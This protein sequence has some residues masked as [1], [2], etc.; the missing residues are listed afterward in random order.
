MRNLR[1]FFLLFCLL[2]IGSV[3]CRK[4]FKELN[5][6]TKSLGEAGAQPGALFSYAQKSLSDYFASASVNYNVFRFFAQYLTPTQYTQE[7]R[8]NISS[9]NISSN[10]F[11]LLYTRVLTNLQRARELIEARNPD[12]KA[13]LGMIGILE[14]YTYSFLVELFGDIPYSQALNPENIHP[15]YDD[16]KTV[17][18]SLADKLDQSLALLS[19]GGESMGV[20]DLVYVGDTS[21]WRKFGNSLKLK[22]A[23]MLAKAD[24]AKA[25]TMAQAASSQVFQSND[26]GYVLHYMNSVPN[27]NPFYSG[28]VYSNRRDFAG[29]NHFIDTMKSWNDPRLP[30]YFDSVK[31]NS[32]QRHP[33]C[34]SKFGY[35][36]SRYKGAV[37]GVVV[38]KD[39][40]SQPY[41]I[42]LAKPEAPGILLDYP[43]I[44]FYL[45]EACCRKLIQANQACNYFK[46]AIEAS[47]IRW[48]GDTT[49]AK[50][51]I[52]K[53]CKRLAKSDCNNVSNG[54]GCS[55]DGQASTAEAE[56]GNFNF[57]L[58]MHMWV[59]LYNRGYAGWNVW[60]RFGHFPKFF[61]VSSSQFNVSNDNIP[62][63]FTYPIEEGNKNQENFARASANI[64]G[65]LLSTK[66]F[67][68]K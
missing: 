53:Q 46:K 33:D 32:A 63:R 19:Q 59:A 3:A 14:V 36:T 1:R 31:N 15:V 49:K 2:L 27:T 45:A 64:G 67:F 39:L 35:D 55:H 50:C 58:A 41:D 30:Y 6:D 54:N 20:A 10:L 51:W 16:A 29:V 43:E 34:I 66:L 38:G 60:R 25:K 4:Y 7:A 47:V 17:Y 5:T 68:F 9:R 18:F 28:Q 62:W 12:N 57:N 56:T 26:D 8:F 40:I 65:D 61:A 48:K 42:P 22:M 11:S 21:K 52:E 37:Y 24:E 23:L 44:Q 13:Q